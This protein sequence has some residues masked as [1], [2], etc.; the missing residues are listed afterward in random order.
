MIDDI[1]VGFEHAVRQPVVAYELPDVFLRI[2]FRAFR[3]QQQDRDVGWNDQPARQVPAGLV[4]QQNGMLA[5]RDLGRDFGQMQVHRLGVAC[6]QDEGGALAVLRADRTEDVSGSGSLVAWRRRP[7][8]A[9][10]PATRDL[11]LLADARLVAKPY[12]Y[13]GWIDALVLGN[14]C[15]SGGE[16]F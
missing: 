12:F 7:R 9:L 14:F 13:I 5:W 8:S 6:G 11:V 1:F 2:K 10:R 15:H 16:S 3:W 4:E